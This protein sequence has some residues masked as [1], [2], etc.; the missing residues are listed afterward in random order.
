MIQNATSYSIAP[1]EF[2]VGKYLPDFKGTITVK[3]DDALLDKFSGGGM[4]RG[5]AGRLILS[6]GKLDIALMFAIWM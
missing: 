4:E 3:P 5:R 6:F 2:L 1:L